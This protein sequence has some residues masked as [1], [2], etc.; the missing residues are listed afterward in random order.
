MYFFYVDESGTH[1]PQV[2]GT[3]ADGTPFEKDWILVKVAVSLFE[4]RW[5]GFEKAI[6]QRKLQ[7]LDQL[8]QSKGLQLDLADAEI[9][10]HWI[11][12]K[13][14][15]SKRPFLA[16]LQPEQLNRLVDFFYDQIRYHKMHV[17][18]VVVDK[19]HLYKYMTHEKLHR[20][21]YE[22]LLERLENFLVNWHPKHRGLVVT[23]S[24]SKEMNKSLALKHSY[25]Q[26]EGTTSGL[27]LGHIVEL[28]MFVESYLSNGVQLADL[29]AH[30]IYHA[31]RLRSLEY[32]RF[33]DLVPAFYTSPLTPT[34]KIDG[35]KVFPD[36][37]DLQDLVTELEKQRTKKEA[38]SGL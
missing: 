21:A 8:R 10:A 13:R 6:N 20:K 5:F 19:R 3:R 23:D 16:N 9:K 35:L 31:F 22:L 18:A 15:R 7:L 24:T 26:R 11:K 32:G 38:P 2:E 12:N 25:F 36:E 29:C 37:S 27:R 33:P 34:E 30:N 28:P 4:Q 1:D 17:F 14:A